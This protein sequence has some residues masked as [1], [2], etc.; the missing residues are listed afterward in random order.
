MINFIKNQHPNKSGI[1]YCLS[2]RECE[3]L[4]QKL[5]E[6][7]IKAS[8][9]HAGMEDTRAKVQKEWHVINCEDLLKNVG[10]MERS[11]L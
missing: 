7:G 6:K 8:A 9:Y 2:R 5:L 3:E 4:A 11:K 10:Q 1:I